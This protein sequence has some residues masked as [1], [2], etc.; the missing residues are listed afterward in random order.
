MTDNSLAPL[1][2]QRVMNRIGRPFGVNPFARAFH[3]DLETKNHAAAFETIYNDNSW[4]S[5]DS[6]SGVGSELQA[7]QNYRAALADLIAQYR[8]DS[9]F[10]APCGD[11]NWM[12]HLLAQTPIQY[13]GGDISG[14]LVEAI[15]QRYPHLS[16]RQF[17]ICHDD[18]PHV[19]VWHCRD[20]LFHLP[21]K[22]IRMA[23]SNF[24]A[25]EI[26]FALLTT[27]RARLMHRNLDLSGIGFRFLDLERTPISLPRPLTY[28]PDYRRGI[29]FPRYVGLWSRAMIHAALTATEAA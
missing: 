15:G 1:L 11:L 3:Y 6:R 2:L 18:F 4:G 29:E 25:S 5:K 23:L 24:V 20:C 22:N 9:L 16:I 27:H 10:D 26:P 28:L 7:T 13:Q 21:F 8:F 12:P 17:D 19:D 14:S